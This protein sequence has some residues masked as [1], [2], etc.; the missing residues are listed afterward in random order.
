[1]LRKITRRALIT[2][3]ML[4]VLYLAVVIGW[5]S[6]T[7][8]EIVA[9][10]PPAASGLTV[11]QADMLLKI[12]DPTFYGHKGLSLADGQGFTTVSSALARDLFLFHG[13]LAGI[14]G[15]LQSFYRG[16]F[17]C[18]KKIDLGRDTMALVLDASVSKD[19]QL[20]IYVAKVYMG[21][22]A[23]VQVSGLANAASAY[24]GKPLSALTELE[25]AGLVGMIKAPNQF[26][27]LQH[28][29]AFAGRRDKVSAVSADSCKSAGWFDTAYMQCTPLE[30]LNTGAP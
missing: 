3:P 27:P 20:A 8:G 6:A 12:E 29:A 15:V 16:V 5:A 28:A 25:L 23:G 14:K 7:V 24:F 19:R 11:R 4:L 10:Y 9:G 17:A 21:T 13:E 18:C 26:H 30:S 22:H 1:M 2:V